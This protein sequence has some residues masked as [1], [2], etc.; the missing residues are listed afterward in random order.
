MAK[1]VLITG[2]TGQKGGAVIDALL[3]YPPD[4]PLTILALTRN[5]N[6]A[7]ARALATKSA[8]IQ[9]ITGDLDD[10]RPVFA[11]TATCIWGVFSVQV[12]FGGGANP[13][14][15]ERQGKALVD[16]ALENHVKHFVYS[17]VDRGANSDSDPT[18]VPQFAS[19]YRIE[20]YLEEKSAGADMTWTIFRLVG[21]MENLN[22]GFVGKVTASMWKYAIP[23]ATPLQFIA[24]ADVGYFVRQA[25]LKPDEY[26]NRVLVLAGDEL[27][28]AQA[29]KVFREKTGKELPRTFVVIA[30]AILKGVKPIKLMFKWF[31]DVGTSVDIPGLR[32]IHPELMTFG[33]WLEKKSGFVRKLS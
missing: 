32:K 22:P 1:A 18:N 15:E 30:W 5:P 33:D 31:V 13:E 10:P 26:S 16:A 3:A 23:A 27:T 29:T 7:A 14:R 19:K 28:Y 17:S 4:P 11:K 20:K 24:L 6:S 9:F 8:S 12:S 2:A 21:Y 25:F